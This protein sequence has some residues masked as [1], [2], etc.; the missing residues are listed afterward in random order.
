MLTQYRI[1]L[2]HDGQYSLTPE[3][4]YAL[5]A[6]LLENAPPAFSER[7]HAAIVTPVSQFLRVDHGRLLWVVNLLGNA[8]EDA[9]SGYLESV[10]SVTLTRKRVRL[11]VS[12]RERRF[13]PDVEAL[14]SAT[15]GKSGAY[16]LRFLTP[17][18]FKSREKYRNFPDSF[19]ILQSLMKKWN[20]CIPECLIEDE[21]G[22]GIQ[23]MA[24]GLSFRHFWIRDSAYHLKGNQIPGFV[25]EFVIE[26]HL[27]GFQR[28]LADAILFFS[29][30]AGVG[31]KT[32]LGMGGVEALRF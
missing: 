16:T 10:Q 29:N 21:D 20:A 25:G 3:W 14:L 23:A 6:A 28:Q 1:Q 8:S 12:G 13:V 27:R 24:D 18:A 15:D 19:L 32:A 2:I 17:A 7:V 26:N 30:F 22:E 5:Y 4:A 9:L 11:H 31:I